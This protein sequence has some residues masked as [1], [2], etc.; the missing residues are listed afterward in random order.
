MPNPYYNPEDLGL[1]QVALI[2]HSD[3]N[4]CFDYRV[5]WKHTET[6]V[7]YTARDSG[8]SCPSPFES[9]NNL[10]DLEVVNFASLE[11]EVNSET[12]NNGPT[13]RNAFLQKVRDA[14]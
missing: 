12:A 13:E 7:L 2:D 3:G 9:Y 1:V 6:G 14:V 8:C 10:A 11:A 4:Y 5:V